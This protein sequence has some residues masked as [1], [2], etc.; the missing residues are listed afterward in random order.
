M[1]SKL[2]KILWTV[3]FTPPEPPEL[4]SYALMIRKLY[5]QLARAFNAM[6]DVVNACNCGGASGVISIFGRTGVVVAQTGDYTVSQVTGAAPLASPN[7]TGSPTAPT[8]T[9]GDNTTKI[10][11]DA[12][13]Q[14][15][16]SGAIS[17]VTSLFIK[18][19]YSASTRTYGSTFQ[20]LTGQPI[21]VLAS[22]GS[23]TA[24]VTMVCDASPTP[25]T[26][27]GEQ[28]SNSGFNVYFLF[29][30]PN[31]FYYKVSGTA[32]IVLSWVEWT[33]IT[34]SVTF[35]GELS[36]SRVLGT[37][38]Q[39]TSGKAMFVVA[40]ISG[41]ASTVVLSAISD[42]GSSPTTT[43]A[44]YTANIASA[45]NTIFFCVPNN[46]YYKVTTSSGGAVAHWNEYTMPF[47]ATKSI[48]LTTGSRGLGN[49]TAFDN[50]TVNTYIGPD[51]FNNQGKDLF[52]SICT[53]FA[54]SGTVSLHIGSSAVP[55]NSTA[56]QAV[57]SNIS[58]DSAPAVG[59]VQPNEFYVV[60]L[61][62]ASV[63]PTLDHWW[64]YKLA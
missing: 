39:N 19:I 55:F 48:D 3:D 60:G 35:S 9:F 23:A 17:P 8:Q 11:T 20:N 46:H 41:L 57:I 6:V 2:N 15:A 5:E 7:L 54:T 14:A 37:V 38:Y 1:P 12:F 43:V 28:L 44:V 50:P 26:V 25:T 58:G 36:G 13:V 18:N 32:G 59:F 47:N 52:L 63:V 49:A 4:K 31:N 22:I 42:S 27:V 24:T 30:V 62:N 45:H 51:F 56:K 10:A 16:V 29:V 64:E 33:I 53:H 34:G 21:I 40:D 61:D